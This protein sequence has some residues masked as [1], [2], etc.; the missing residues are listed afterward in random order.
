MRARP[1]PRRRLDGDEWV[2]NG[3]KAFITNSGTDIT[4]VVTVTAR[5]GQNEDGSPQISAIMVPAGTPGFTVESAY[6]KLGWHAS[7][8]HGLSFSDCRVP[9]DHL[10]G[11]QGDGFKQ[12][13]ETLD[14]G[15]IAI[16]A[17]AVGL[18]QA[19]LEAS[20]DYARTR[21]AFGRPIGANQGVSFQIADLAVMVEAART[22]T[23]KAAWLKDE[24]HAGRRSVAEVKQAAADRASCTPPR[25][26]CR[27]PAS[28]RRSSAATASWRST[29]SR[30]STVTPRSSR[31]ARAPARCSAWS[32]PAASA[33][34]AP[35]P[36]PPAHHLTSTEPA[37]MTDQ[38]QGTSSP[39][40]F[41]GPTEGGDPRVAD[42]RRRLNAAH[43]ASAAPPA[44][45]AAKLAAQHKLYV[46]E[47]I[48]LLFDE[49][50]F[51]EDGRYANA[52]APG[53]PADG[54]VTGR[55]TVDG[56]PAIV[57][58]NDPTVKAGSW[59]A[60]TVEK[61]VRATEMALREE[62]PIFWFVDSAG[63]RIT[64][65][66][67]LFPGRRGAG[68][69]FHNQVALSGKVPQICCLFGPVGGRR[70]LHPGVHRH[71]DHGRGQRLDVPRQP[72]HGGDGRRGDGVPG[73]DGRC[74]DALHRL[75]LR[76][77]A[78][79]RRRRRDRAGQAVLLLPARRAGAPSH[80]PT[81]RRSRRRR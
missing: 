14:D 19:C 7:D 55:G 29:P 41:A 51:V 62:L 4:S 30:G 71:R 40:P 76:R 37:P 74:P 18:A 78:G 24:L 5:T 46:R 25:R 58:A 53:L 48:D 43:A 61:I 13:L 47:R 72:P 32:S 52:M 49:G 80:R 50:S 16:S 57:V 67:E 8:T 60:R 63:A 64:D 79:H 77:P 73:G 2:I 75:R 42:V 54:V 56:R 3:A 17:L 34:P 27:R 39:A 59:G 33:C 9:A 69:I 65:Q 44:K 10:L 15:R 26:R 81:C 11:Q 20:T 23:Y 70:G 68:R 22:L 36:A 21:I 28:P 38:Q 31:S 6:D 1:A 35:D 66:V 45:A 12:F